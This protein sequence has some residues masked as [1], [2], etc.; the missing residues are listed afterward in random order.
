MKGI[1]RKK[2]A[3]QRSFLN[4]AIGLFSFVFAH[5]CGFISSIEFKQLLATSK[6]FKRGDLYEKLN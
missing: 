4:L 3:L 1:Q 5:K 2:T 6:Y